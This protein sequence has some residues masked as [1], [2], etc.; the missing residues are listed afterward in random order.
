[1]YQ[2]TSLL[3]PHGKRFK[4]GFGPWMVLLKADG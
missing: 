2:G 1:M 3:V 4:R